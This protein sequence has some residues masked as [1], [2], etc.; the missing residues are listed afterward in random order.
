MARS[1]SPTMHAVAGLFD[2]LP[3][4][5]GNGPVQLA[6]ALP[7]ERLSALPGFPEAALP[8][9]G[10]VASGRG[11]TPEACRTS[12]L[13]EAIELV[14]CCAWAD[15]PL[16]RATEAELGPVALSPEALNGF[17]DAQ[18]D[19][20]DAWN[21]T[22]GG[23][24]WRPSRRDPARALDWVP[25][26]DA[27]GGAAAYAPADF[28]FIGRR[29]AG[30][31]EAVAI[32]DSNGCAVGSTPEAAR[33]SAL[34]ELIER[35]ATARWWYGRRRRPPIA[36][37]AAGIDA[38]LCDW[39]RERARRTWL[40]DI[41]SDLEVPVVAAASSE[42]DGR[43]VALGFAAALDRTVAATAALTELVQ[44]ERSVALAGALGDAAG[45]WALW[46]RRVDM[47]LPPLDAV[48]ALPPQA[49]PAGADLTAGSLSAVLEACAR[50]GTDLW[51][52]D[53]SRAALGLPAVRALS[54]TVCHS[55][56]RLRR[57]RLHMSPSADQ[58][59]FAAA[60]QQPPLTV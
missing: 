50:N 40:F 10:R 23:F 20:R 41:T 16:V 36:P 38:T 34:L 14:S 12:A 1:E 56:P 42:T 44:L 47:S 48:S 5:P 28:A 49:P 18:I 13:G 31:P 60:A 25:V 39:L 51:F 22:Y 57:P 4:P 43:E 11:L 29:A 19:E 7:G 8:T 52:C 30:D 17:S 21:E 32:G 3:L 58:V 6:L 59:P 15:E 54:T 9:T 46:R 27:F 33:L 53:M 37:G 35:D 55:K 24:D 26:N 2:L 45:L